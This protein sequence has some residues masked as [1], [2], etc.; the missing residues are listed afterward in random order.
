MPSAPRDC[1]SGKSQALEQCRQGLHCQH[2]VT[3]SNVLHGPPCPTCVPASLLSTGPRPSARHL[4]S[5]SCPKAAPREMP[6][7][8][9]PMHLVQTHCHH[10]A[11]LTPVT[12]PARPLLR[13]QHVAPPPLASADSGTVPPAPSGRHRDLPNETMMGL[14]EEN[15]GRLQS[16][17]GKHRLLHNFL[18]LQEG[19]KGTDWCKRVRLAPRSL[20]NRG[21]GKM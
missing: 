12:H 10:T 15:V 1:P 9:L 7:P 2:V 21:V 11:E 4:S 13:S 5:F 3:S 8:C 20:M 16:W 19:S 18:H 6:L 17:G 14:M